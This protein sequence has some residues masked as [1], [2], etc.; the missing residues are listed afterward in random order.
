MYQHTHT[1]VHIYTNG[2]TLYILFSISYFCLSIYLEYTCILNSL[3][4]LPSVPFRDYT[5]F[6][7]PFIDVD[8]HV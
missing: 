4:W 3:G 1:Y 5:V 7:Q 6:F 2:I 8:S